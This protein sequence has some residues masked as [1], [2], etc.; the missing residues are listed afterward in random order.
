MTIH[1]PLMP[2]P[3]HPPRGVAGIEVTADIRRGASVLTYRV[4]GQT[5]VPALVAPERTDELWKHTCFEL[6]VKP[7]GGEGYF[8]FNFAPST[9]WAA[10]RFDGYRDGMRDQ[11]LDAPVIEPVED[12][13]RVSVDLGGLPEGEW[14]VAITAVIEEADGTKSYWSATHG[15]GKPD[16]HADAGFVVSL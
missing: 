16:F 4:D 12:G 6:F 8:E 9:A 15:A 5:L 14:R 11:P 3:D 10:Y 7:A 1:V 2:H 13:V